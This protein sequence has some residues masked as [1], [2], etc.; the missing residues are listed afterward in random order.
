[1]LRLGVKA[2]VFATPFY[3]IIAEMLPKCS[4]MIIVVYIVC[5][6]MNIQFGFGA[7]S[8]LMDTFMGMAR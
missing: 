5:K 4:N 2:T 3:I 6:L 8:M 7:I 1:M